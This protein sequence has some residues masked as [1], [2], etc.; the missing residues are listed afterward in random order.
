[1]AE[2]TH[3]CP[4]ACQCPSREELDT[5]TS[6]CVLDEAEDLGVMHLTGGGPLARDDLD[7][8]VRSVARGRGSRPSAPELDHVQAS[9]QEDALLVQRPSP[10]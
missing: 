10:P 9:V 6:L 2:I 7:A 3:R 1:M 4:L 8:H 5:A